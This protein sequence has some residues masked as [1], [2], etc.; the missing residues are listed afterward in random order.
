MKYQTIS[1]VLKQ[2]ELQTFLDLMSLVTQPAGMEGCSKT[3][4]CLLQGLYFRVVGKSHISQHQ[5]K[6][7]VPI[8]EALA[9]NEYWTGQPMRSII[10]SA[11]INRLIGIFDQKLATSII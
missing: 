9:F 3:V 2:H 6:I 7:A 8:P 5:Y 10:S 11:L 4:I 1:I